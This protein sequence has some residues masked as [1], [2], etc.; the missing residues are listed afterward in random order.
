[1]ALARNPSFWWWLVVVWFIALF[2]LSSIPKLP[3]GPDI[4][5]EDKILHTV[6]YSIGAAC[7][8]LARR[9]RHNTLGGMAATFTAV[10]FCMAV[11]AFDEFHQSFVT[12]RSGNDPFDWLA[13]TLG[14]FLGSLFGRMTWR[15]LVAHK[16][17]I[18][19]APAVSPPAPDPPGK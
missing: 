18:T 1:M 12:N 10:L 15:M 5:F 8:Y 19:P 7:F 3:P 6:Y 17:T 4:P 13:D 9:F 2:L 16:G 11:G 14:G